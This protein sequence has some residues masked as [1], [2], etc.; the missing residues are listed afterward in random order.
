MA[1]F[2]IT[3]GS[4]F[5]GSEL[6]TAF[7]RQGHRVLVLKH[8][9]S[10]LTRLA[11][12]LRDVTLF[13]LEDGV[14]APFEAG[15]FVNAVIH[16][17]T[18]Y[19]RRA[20]SLSEVLAANVTFPLKL[21]ETASATGTPLFV[22]A[23]TALTRRISPYS[24][25]KGQFRAWGRVHAQRK[26]IRFLNIRLEQFYGP[27]DDL[28]KFPMHVIASFVRNIPELELTPGDQVRDFLYIS[29]VV[30]A[31]T[32]LLDKFLEAGP[33]Y[34]TFD[35]GTGE[36]L[37]IREFVLAVR[38]ITGASTTPLF[39][40]APYRKNELMKSSA[41]ARKLRALGWTP[42]VSLKTGIRKTIVGVAT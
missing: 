25:S 18:C 39:G 28:W 8:R 21:L 40:A 10:R 31:Y 2:V 27:G 7:V 6:T 36:P 41:M 1:T 20:E 4:G 17:A 30:E 38:R 34:A 29:D 37:S 26:T 42:R 14:A 3:G 5:L 12:I 11:P 9:E 32:L 13:D 19:G 23:D 22:N 24:L 15:S 35:V 16:T 33:W